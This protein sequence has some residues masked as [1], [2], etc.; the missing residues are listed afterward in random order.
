MSVAFVS[1]SSATWRQ[2]T[3]PDLGLLP[4]LPVWKGEAGNTRWET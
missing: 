3:G 2:T 4:G 1:L